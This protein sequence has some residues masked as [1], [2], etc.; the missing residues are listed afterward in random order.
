MNI[1]SLNPKTSR[2]ASHPRT[3][4]NKTTTIEPQL[5]IKTPNST[6]PT[7]RAAHHRTPNP[8][9]EQRGRHRNPNPALDFKLPSPTSD[10]FKQ[11]KPHDIPQTS[12]VVTE[13]FDSEI[14]EET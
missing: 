6:K 14:R 4:H 13:F 3:S 12:C 11:F 7:S 9:P 8:I 2:A 1:N 5:F 10:S